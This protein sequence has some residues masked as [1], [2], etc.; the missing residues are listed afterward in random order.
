MTKEERY[1]KFLKE[2][3]NWPRYI[4]RK[5]R[6]KQTRKEKSAVSRLWVLRNLEKVRHYQRMWY[7]KNKSKK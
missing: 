2:N 3:P 5:P 1:E 6:V 7:R 4:P